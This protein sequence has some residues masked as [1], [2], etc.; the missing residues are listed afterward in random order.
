MHF[1]ARESERPGNRA[2]GALAVSPDAAR[3]DQHVH[4]LLCTCG[5]M[6]SRTRCKAYPCARNCAAGAPAAR[7]DVV[8]PAQQ[9]QQRLPRRRGADDETGPHKSTLSTPSAV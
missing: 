2:R 3:H 1:L 8:S 6:V 9:F 5:T 4:T 7:L